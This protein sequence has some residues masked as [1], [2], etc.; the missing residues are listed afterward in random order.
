VARAAS[1]ARRLPW[2]PTAIALAGLAL[3]SVALAPFE[4]LAS[5]PHP[6]LQFPEARD[7]WTSQPLQGDPYFMGT[8]EAGARLFRR[9]QRGANPGL[10]DTIDLLIVYESDPAVDDNHLLSSKSQWPGPNWNRQSRRRA[11]NWD[12]ARETDLAVAAHA[13]GPERAVVSSWR[14]R[15]EGPW[16]EFARS[17]L[18][19]ESS[20]FRR[21][22]RR[23]LVQLVAYSPWQDDPVALDRAR[24]R[25]ERFISI[26]R[27]ELEAL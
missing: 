23:A 5:A 11:H 15:D 7:V 4:P 26:F 8:A 16:R 10:I 6:P 12:L 9:Y 19:L 24:L 22:P 3:L 1:A 27:D 20:P 21:V 13:S 18:A 14:V 17:L 2:R 25:I